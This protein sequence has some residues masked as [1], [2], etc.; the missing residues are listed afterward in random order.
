MLRD[1]AAQAASLSLAAVTFHEYPLPR[2][3]DRRPRA[4]L[5]G[6]TALGFRCRDDV[7]EVT[8]LAQLSDRESRR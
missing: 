2:A 1:F 6:P 7:V 8:R 3:A 5:L 4:T